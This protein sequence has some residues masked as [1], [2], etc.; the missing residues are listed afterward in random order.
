MLDKAPGN[1][2]VSKLRAILLLE[3]EFNALY[4]II[5]NC[6]IL[7]TLEIKNIILVEIMGDRRSQSEAHVVFNKKT[8]C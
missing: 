4:K 3:A 6:R 7:P 2:L 1:I 5:F 8:N